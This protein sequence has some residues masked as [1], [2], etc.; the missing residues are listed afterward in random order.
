MRGL[1]VVFSQMIMLLACTPNMWTQDT[2][3]AS[4]AGHVEF[5]QTTTSL[6]ARLYSPKASYA[7]AQQNA[8]QTQNDARRVRAAFVGRDG[9]FEFTG[10]RS[11]SYLLELYTGDRLLYQQ[12]VSTQDKQP[13]EISLNAVL[14]SSQSA[15]VYKKKGWQPADMTSDP[16]SGVFVL[17]HNGGISKLSVDQHVAR[18]D[19]LFRLKGAYQGYAVAAS[20]QSVYVVANSKLGCSVTRYLLSTKAVAERSLGVGEHCAGIA[21]DGT[22]VYV[23]LPD[24]SEIRYLS[25]WDASS[26]GSWSV[27]DVDSIGPATFDRFGNRLIVA[28]YSGKAY[29]IS[30]SDGGKQ[31]LA[32][33]LGWVNSVTASRQ[34]ILLASGTKILS[35]ARSDNRGENPPPSLQSLT[36]GHIVGVTVDA[37]DNAWFADYDKE[38]V[39]GPLP[40]N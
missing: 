25:S 35:L 4:I 8:Q 19:T 17:D 11:G 22:A 40:L 5:G 13:V 9:Q 16:S 7:D 24:K 27:N 33:N 1:I 36:G 38:L 34:H 37:T 20:A 6:I 30:T 39:Q 28:D 2:G 15:Q 29:A 10:L 21:T 14:G 26:Y 12:V 3:S 18:I 32:S 31:L 23:T